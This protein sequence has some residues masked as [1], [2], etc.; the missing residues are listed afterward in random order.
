MPLIPAAAAVVRM[1]PV[2]EEGRDPGRQRESHRAEVPL[3]AACD[4]VPDVG[5]QW[6]E[7]RHVAHH[8]HAL[9]SDHHAIERKHEQRT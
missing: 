8:G 6:R 3:L 9:W 2:L 4:R 1:Q 5:R 7:G